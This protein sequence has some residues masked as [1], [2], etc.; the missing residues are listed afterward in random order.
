MILAKSFHRHLFILL[1]VL[2][3][4]VSAIISNVKIPTLVM[5]AIFCVYAVCY[6]MDFKYYLSIIALFCFSV[7]IALFN[8]PATVFYGAYL[9]VFVAFYYIGIKHIDFVAVFE[10][11][12]FIALVHLFF[13]ITCLV[14]FSAYFLGIDTNRLLPTGSRNSL[15]ALIFVIS[16]LAFVLSKRSNIAILCIAAIM[17]FL[18]GGRTNQFVALCLFGFAIS[19]KLNS[20]YFNIFIFISA[21]GGLLIIQFTLGFENLFNLMF[22][23]EA[24][25]SIGL[26]SLRSIVW[27]EWYE[28]LTLYKFIFGFNLSDLAFVSWR[29]NGNPHNSFILI[30]SYTGIL[31]VIFTCWL[32]QKLLYLKREIA[33][34]IG[35]LLFKGF[36]DTIILPSSLDIFI[37][38]FLFIG[39]HEKVKHI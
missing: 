12:S 30:H 27:G 25:T 7:A 18:L 35:L 29:L 34:F 38:I 8:G 37:L 6:K 39:H 24:G 2:A 21:L 23:N 13:L 1:F 4:F 32:L 9:I 11:K 16:A 20:K 33:F 17:L 22:V 15:G 36:F 5:L 26:R 28:N 14:F 3:G 31:F 19:S 10:N